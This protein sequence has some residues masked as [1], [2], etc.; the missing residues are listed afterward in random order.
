MIAR[1]VG[2]TIRCEPKRPLPWGLYV[3]TRINGER[4]SGTR[5]FATEAEAEAQYPVAAAEIQ[6]RRDD[7]EH[8]ARLKAALNAPP[9]L[10]TA[11]RGTV[12]FE[13][14][15][16]R[17]LTEHVKEMCAAAT[18][19]NYKRLLDAHLLP[20]MRTWPVADATM[21]GARIKDV[22]KVQL[23]ARGVPLPTRLA[24][25]ACLSA[26]F[27]WAKGELL[28]VTLT[29]NPAE[30]LG[31]FIRDKTEK[32]VQLKQAANPMTRVQVE[33]FLTWQET[34]R[35]ELY[36][37]FVWL[38]D[39]GSRVGEACALKWT[40]LDLDNGK[41]HVVAAFSASQLWAERQAGDERGL[42]EKDTKTH[43]SDQ[44]VDLSDRVVEVYGKLKATNREAWLKRGRRPIQEPVHCLLTRDGTPRRPD[45]IVYAA[46]RA[47]CDA[48]GLKGQTGEP[49]T[50]HCLRDTFATL[51]LLEGKPLGWV[52]MML[53]HADTE[54]TRRHYVKWIRLAEVNPLSTKKQGRES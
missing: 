28:P 17:W 32:H 10:P 22:L 54:T 34:N 47:G 23:F 49:F 40:V 26:L 35:P 14:V 6:R 1:V 7:A 51:S 31:M 24:C 52:S 48:L 27:S 37:L 16:R 44:Y 21:T 36:P 20:V 29:R 11:P 15:A 53:G 9:E 5:F 4:V 43:R 8:Q 2:V 39:E 45:K 19:R 30:G 12:L 38:A 46:F 33:A 25:H 18:Y 3:D 13:T 50:I 41:G 42:G